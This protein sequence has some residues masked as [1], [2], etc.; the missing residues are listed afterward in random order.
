M[1]YANRYRKFYFFIYRVFV[2]AALDLCCPI[3]GVTSYGHDEISALDIAF[4][5]S[6]QRFACR[7]NETLVVVHCTDRESKRQAWLLERSKK[8]D[9]AAFMELMEVGG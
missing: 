7:T 6:Y 9:D 8:R 2:G 1:R 4:R 3:G 5:R